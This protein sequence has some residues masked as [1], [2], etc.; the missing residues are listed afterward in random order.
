MKKIK[1]NF[2]QIIEI[3]I[4]AMVI[5]IPF[6]LNIPEFFEEYLQD[7][8]ATPD[9]WFYYL[10]IEKG[11]AVASTV[12]FVAAYLT[13]RKFN[14]TFVMN[15]AN[16]YHS[17]PYAWYWFCAKLLGI[18]K[19]NLV[20]VP[21]ATQFKLVI[22]SVFDD[23]PLEETAFPVVEDDSSVSVSKRNWEGKIREINLILEDTYPINDKQLPKL[24]KDLPTLTISRN[25][26]DGVA[27][28]F[29][30]KFISAVE[31]EIRSM[32]GGLIVNVF[33]TTNPMNTL[34]IASR[35]FKM[36]DRGNVDRLYVYQQ[37]NSNGR[38]F[39]N[40]GNRVV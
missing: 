38:K 7:N 22:N 16:V 19:C 30:E 11:N 23:Y 2:V 15:R 25:D 31:N 20:L 6:L 29:S 8:Y 12:L 35:V 32:R 39:E 3:L 34:H 24:K 37:R 13:I 40:K 28:H 14:S 33:S 1:D 18:K 5:A 21:I 10:A 36:A 27:R 26:G 17:Y 9:N 4:L